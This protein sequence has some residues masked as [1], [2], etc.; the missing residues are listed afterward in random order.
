MSRN[1]VYTVSEVISL[2]EEGKSVEN[3]FISGE[4]F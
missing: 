4:T 1:H 3:I 2:L